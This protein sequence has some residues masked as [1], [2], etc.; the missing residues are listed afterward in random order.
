M[1]FIINGNIWLAVNGEFE[2][3]SQTVEIN[4]IKCPT[5]LRAINSKWII[6]LQSFVD[7]LHEMTRDDET[8][9]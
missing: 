8:N 2:L 5:S 4:A 3:D 6:V 7:Y 9:R 1:S